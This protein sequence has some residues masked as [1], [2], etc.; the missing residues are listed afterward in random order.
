MVMQLA[1]KAAEGNVKAAAFVM[2]AMQLAGVAMVAE[3]ASTAARKRGWVTPQEVA[4]FRDFA[5]VASD[6][7][8][9]RFLEG[10][11]DDGV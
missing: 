7:A 10:S 6:E 9:K 5:K 3:R 2:D 11:D 1:S 4:I 8:I